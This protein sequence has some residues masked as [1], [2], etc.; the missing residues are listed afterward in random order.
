MDAGFAGGRDEHVVAAHQV[1]ARD[2]ADA[3]LGQR[4]AL[5]PAG[6]GVPLVHDRVER[7]LDLAVRAVAAEGAAVRR[8]RKHDVCA[9]GHVRVLGETGQTGDGALQRPEQ[10]PCLG[11]GVPA[12]LGQRAGDT[13]RGKGEGERGHQC[14]LD[15]LDLVAHGLALGRA[16]PV[17]ERID[18]AIRRQVRRDEPERGTRGAVVA[19]ELACELLAGLGDPRSRHDDGRAA[20]EQALDQGGGDG[21]G[22]GT[23]DKGDVVCVLEL[24]GLE[25]VGRDFL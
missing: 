2:P 6:L 24:W 20:L 11:F 18:I 25:R 16:D 9:G 7:G 4:H 10:Q 17:D 5:G 14:G 1:R 19:E 13:R 12:D 21:A 3:R 22:C 15:Q 23:G 8:A